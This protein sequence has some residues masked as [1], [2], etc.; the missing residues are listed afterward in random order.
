M[1]EPK[2][3]RHWDAKPIVWKQRSL[4]LSQNKKLLLP[5]YSSFSPSSFPYAVQL[6]FFKKGKRMLQKLE[7]AYLAILR[8]V[9]IAVG[10]VLLVTVAILGFNSL[11]AIQFEPVAKEITPQVSEQELIKGII[12]KPSSQAA[13]TH[14][15]NSDAPAID[16]NL[17]FSERTAYAVVSFLEKFPDKAQGADKAQVLEIVKRKANSQG[18]PKLITL[19]AKGLADSIEKTLSDKSVNNAGQAT[20][21][22]DVV[23]KALT[24]FDEKFNAQIMK[25]NT[26]NT[27]NQMKYMQEKADG[28]KSL[29][30]SAGAFIS[31]LMIVFLSII[32]RI[33]RNLRHLE[34]KSV[35]AA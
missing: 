6:E 9:I 5:E 23:N 15:N 13:E 29:Y 8:F 2:L 35:V 14:S 18:D 11:K 4:C 24:I 19:Y 21:P 27:A 34:N 30:V 32:I 7:N 31:F 22:L 33:E 16:P 25:A 26:E 1:G 28:M 3:G 10:G 12:E 20:S 17:V